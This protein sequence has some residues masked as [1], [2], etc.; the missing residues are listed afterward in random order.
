MWVHI[1]T[2]DISI[3]LHV[4]AMVLHITFYAKTTSIQWGETRFDATS[5]V[6]MKKEKK[7]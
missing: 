7:M 5:V 2:L 4:V 3:E 6:L 1:L